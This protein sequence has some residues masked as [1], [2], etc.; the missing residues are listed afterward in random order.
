MILWQLFLKLGTYVISL[1]YLLS[2]GFVL[3]A[4][5]EY[6]LLVR[7]YLVNTTG[8]ELKFLR[9]INLVFCLF[10]SLTCIYNI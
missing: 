4:I 5:W 8:S 2:L 6:L 7:I 9:L 10:F 1:Y 3:C